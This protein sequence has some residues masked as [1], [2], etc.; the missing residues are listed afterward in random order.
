MIKLSNGEQ[1]IFPMKKIFAAALV[2]AV[3]IVIGVG[4]TVSADTV[5]QPSALFDTQLATT[6]SN[7]TSTTSFTLQQ[8]TDGDGNALTGNMCFTVDG[9]LSNV[10]YI[11]GSVSGTAVSNLVRGVS[12]T[13]GV[14]SVTSHLQSHRIGADV[15]ITDFPYLSQITRVLNGVGTLPNYLNY[16][17]SIP[18]VSAPT[19]S[20]ALPN[21]GQVTS[22]VTSVATSGAPDASQSAKGLVQIAS[23]AQIALGTATSTDGTQTLWNVVSAGQYG[24]TYGAT[25]TVTIQQYNSQLA[26]TTYTFTDTDAAQHLWTVPNL[27]TNEYIVVTAS[28]GQGAN[29]GATTCPG[30]NGYGAG[31]GGGGGSTALSNNISYAGTFNLFASGGGGGSGA[32]GGNCGGSAGGGGG[33]L[34]GKISNASTTVTAGTVVYY[35]IGLRPSAGGNTSGGG[36]GV[37]SSGGQ[38]HLNGTTGGTGSGFTSGNGGTGATDTVAGGAGGPSQGYSGN[39]TQGGIGGSNGNAISSGSFSAGSTST[40][41]GNGS[42]T[43]VLYYTQGAENVSSTVSGNNFGG[44]VTV[45]AT[46]A[47]LSPTTSTI[48]FSPWNF[49]VSGVSCMA[50]T[51]A[52]SLAPFI[53]AENTTSVEFGF[54][55][56]IAGNK[57]DYQCNA[58]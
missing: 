27:G 13:D 4:Y 5:Y 14:T 37:G 9:G 44:T 7:S 17:S 30:A 46:T 56:T 8:G 50:N 36:V 11:C 54:G 29:G 43:V 40:A 15:K 28:A 24:K 31:G 51:W 39:Y 32:A 3:G 55:S 52:S 18:I 48:N 41:S 23:P 38:G 2:L 42:I 19:S 16:A 57:Y 21:W 12:F 35:T 6:I 10:E 33:G 58:Y 1:R 26:S 47:H 22:Y 49:P 53:L 25:P 34:G 20:Y 45:S